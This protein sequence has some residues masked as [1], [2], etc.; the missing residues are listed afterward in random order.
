M[1]K[2]DLAVRLM[3]EGFRQSARDFH[4]SAADHTC[5]VNVQSSKWNA[6]AEGSFTIKT[7]GGRA[8]FVEWGAQHGLSPSG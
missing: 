1:V 8:R 2:C 3:A 4:R 5:V 6:G 7:D